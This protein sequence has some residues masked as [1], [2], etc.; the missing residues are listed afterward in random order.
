MRKRLPTLGVAVRCAACALL[1][2]AEAFVLCSCHSKP[3]PSR[4][5]HVLLI[6]IDTC[7]ADYLGC[8]GRRQAIT[9]NIDAIAAQGCLFESAVSPVP[10]TLPAHSSILTGTVP[11][12]HG[13]R[14]NSAYRL[15][16]S[17]DTLAEVLNEQGFATAAVVSAFVLDSKFGLDQGFDEYHDRFLRE[18]KAGEIIERKGDEAT[19]IALEWLTKHKD[20]RSFLFLHYFDPHFPYEP[21]EPFDTQFAEDPYAGEIAFVDLC[22]GRVIRHLRDLGIY[23][24]SLIIVAGDHGEMLGEHGE[25]THGY[26][27]YQSA[28]K[29]PWIIRAPD[30]R[31]G[32][33]IPDLVGLIDIVPTACALLGIQR[34]PQAQGVDLSAHLDRTVPSDKDRVIYAESL[35][36]TKYNANPLVALVTSRWKYIQ[37]TRPELYDLAR[38]PTESNN[39]AASEPDCAKAM[40]DQLRRIIEQQHRQPDEDSRLEMGAEDLRRLEA[41]GYL[42]GASATEELDIDPSKDDPKD[43]IASHELREKL[44]LLLTRKEH[45]GAQ[46]VCE[47]LLRERPDRPDGYIG[48]AMIAVEQHDLSGAI[49]FLRKATELEPHD[50]VANGMLGSLLVKTGRA[51]EAIDCFRRVLDRKPDSFAAHYGLAEALEARDKA[52][53]ALAHYRQALQFDPEPARAHHKLGRALQVKGEID[54][55]IRHF[56]RA[57]QIKPDLAEVQHNLASL[58]VNQGRLDEAIDHYRQA[59]A[60]DPDYARAHHNLG[61]ALGGKGR[62]AEA[63]VHFLEALRLRNDWL[64]PMNAAA[65][66]LATH[67]DAAVRSPK[68]AVRLAERAAELTK[69]E[70]AGILAAANVLDTLAAAYAAAGRFDRAVATAE[71][72][73]ARAAAAG[74][75][76]LAKS[77]RKRLALYRR[78]LPY[79]EQVRAGDKRRP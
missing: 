74:S 13:V 26:F 3:A 16:S 8:Y 21:P 27:V 40:Q 1:I 18:H 19:N 14:D 15:G 63:L 61:V 9:P 44:S 57:L 50:V 35:T 73:A 77:I 39:L 62:T 42:A 34:P 5:D 37:T 24:S 25:S 32:G 17:I 64:E 46:K 2:G 29:V 12:Y 11:P 59:L 51:D 20:D 43:L 72:A 4:I 36:P 69:K 28:V 49:P 41:L 38:D 31:A 79:R 70:R 66:I 55:A 75:R 67:A 7:R 56:Q 47:E 22:I 60:I 52:D 45:A 65:W 53:E 10:L 58:L 6:S 78:G 30:R 71:A 48:L 54:E 68:E 33:R 76:S 23:E